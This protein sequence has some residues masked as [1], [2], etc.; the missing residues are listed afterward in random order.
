MKKFLHISVVCTYVLSFVFSVFV[1]AGQVSSNEIMRSLVPPGEMTGPSR[2]FVPVMLSGI[3]L[4]KND[5]LRF[6][7]LVDSGYNQLNA[8]EVKAESQKLVRYFM[9]ALTIPA[10]DLWVNLSPY[11]SDRIITQVLGQTELGQD[12]L[13]QDYQLKQ[14]TSS[15]I[16]PEQDLGR[17]FWQKVYQLAYERYGVTELPINT[18]NKVWILPD[19]AQIFEKDLSVF[20]VKTRLKV[21]LDEDYVAWQQEADNNRLGTDRTDESEEQQIGELSA[22]IVRDLVIPEIEKE[23]NTGQNFSVLRQIYHSL[24]L[25]KWY[26]QTVTNSLLSLEY[27]DQNKI[28]GVDADDPD[29]KDRIYEKYIQAYNIGVFDYVKEEYDQ[30]AQEV[31]PRKY[32]SGGITQLMN[33]EL[34]TVDD[35]MLIDESAVGRRFVME[36]GA[37]PRKAGDDAAML[38]EDTAPLPLREIELIDKMFESVRKEKRWKRDQIID[39]REMAEALVERLKAEGMTIDAEVIENFLLRTPGYLI[40]GNEFL[41]QE[42]NTLPGKSNGMESVGMGRATFFEREDVQYTYPL[43]AP[44]DNEAIRDRKVEHEQQHVFDT[45]D[46]VL[47]R[48]V[49]FR[50]RPEYQETVQIIQAYLIQQI[51]ARMAFG[52]RIAHELVRLENVDFRETL[53]LDESRADD[54]LI[55]DVKRELLEEYIP[56]LVMERSHFMDGDAL[57]GEDKSSH[58]RFKLLR[59]TWA[60]ILTHPFAMLKVHEYRELV[61]EYLL[62]QQLLMDELAKAPEDRNN[63]LI[64]RTRRR[65][66]MIEK[67]LS[68]LNEEID[69]DQDIAGTQRTFFL[70]EFVGKP[71]AEIDKAGEGVVAHN[72]LD[73]TEVKMQA[74]FDMM[75][76]AGSWNRNI[77]AVAE[78]YQSFTFVKGR[79]D[80]QSYVTSYADPVEIQK[81]KKGLEAGRFKSAYD[82]TRYIFTL[83]LVRKRLKAEK[84]LFDPDYELLLRGEEISDAAVSAILNKDESFKAFMEGFFTFVSDYIEETGLDTESS[85]ADFLSI[86]FEDKLFE[87]MGEILGVPRFEDYSQ[88][89]DLSE[90]IF[91]FVML[92]SQTLIEDITE[93]NKDD[94]VIVFVDPSIDVLTPNEV[95]ALNQRYGRIVAFVE[96]GRS[97]HAINQFPLSVSSVSDINAANVKE[98]DFVIV[99]GSSKGLGQVTVRPKL[100]TR[101]QAYQTR[102]DLE[103]KMEYFF[104]T[105]TQ[106][107]EVGGQYYHN[108]VSI[109]AQAR[110]DIETGM[111]KVA[112]SGVG[113]HRLELLFSN[114]Y[115]VKLWSDEGL[116]VRQFTEYLNAS[117]FNETEA[118]DVR[119]LW[120]PRLDDV[121]GEKIPIILEEYLARVERDQGKEQRDQLLE[122]ILRDYNGVSFYF[123]RDESGE[124]P[125]YEYGQRQLRALF[126]AYNLAENKRLGISFPNTRNVE[127]FMTVDDILAMIDE[128]KQQSAEDIFNQELKGLQT[129]EASLRDAIAE[130]ESKEPVTEADNIQLDNY[131]EQL[132]QLI[133]EINAFIENR[134]DYVKGLLNLFEGVKTGFYVEEVDQLVHY[135]EM[136]RKSDFIAIGT[137]D[138]LKSLFQ[139]DFPDISRFDS[140]YSNLFDEPQPRLLEVTWFMT[141]VSRRHGKPFII[142]GDWGDSVRWGGMIGSTLASKYN[143]KVY[144]AAS[145]YKSARLRS[146]MQVVDLQKLTN[147][148]AQT[149]EELGLFDEVLSDLDKRYNNDFSRGYLGELRDR[150]GFIQRLND[151]QTELDDVIDLE[152]ARREAELDGETLTT[153]D[154]MLIQDDSLGGI[155][156]NEIDL[157]GT[158]PGIVIEFDQQ[159]VQEIMREGAVDGFSPVIIN[160]MP[161]TSV[162]PLLGLD[163]EQ[164]D[165]RQQARISRL[166]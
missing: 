65:I 37:F 8:Q 112:A 52:Y 162:L 141:K 134:N 100:A 125:F 74:F 107:L 159:R 152:V 51:E 47:A 79:L 29:L 87:Q 23:I 10:E 13:A 34:E 143:A 27:V 3:T 50:P 130:I 103:R 132:G 139:K 160:I 22:A 7:F 156:F 40:A 109:G 31:V 142:S 157:E 61:R 93:K 146:Y 59:S 126:K 104:A 105:A 42:Q 70:D 114:P 44:I 85:I 80:S 101:L 12:L 135:D 99:Q 54:D 36:T 144:T 95:G 75:R 15:L 68:V 136:V 19:R 17:E 119:G 84:K 56:A 72:V 133:D 45:F 9:S 89:M 122:T 26:K 5:P 78:N 148:Q 86:Y 92:L 69:F 106:P 153:D 164:P 55:G 4:H 97:P 82:K 46:K 102:D 94:S 76:E 14:L 91:D 38:T 71:L 53:G 11:E 155:D 151:Y 145:V 127:G 137:N 39:A 30:Y 16:Y 121:S 43:V 90:K 2:D 67:R 64:T 1:P 33:V 124:R 120:M 32:F 131:I 115:N 129:R 147:P 165:T 77:E 62:D 140:Q 81:R 123:Y 60:T 41:G 117:I 161:V 28:L 25:A 48:R 116:M 58:E 150:E 138:M 6:D 63:I 96:Q 98:G 24:I 88:Q 35:A 66:E 73:R 108:L 21:M 111:A 83:E 166:P 113:L 20:I 163:L 154:A 110:S 118:S 149:T 18:F 49:K 158:G 57:F 128:A